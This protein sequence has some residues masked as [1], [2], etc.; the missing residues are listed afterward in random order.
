M[1]IL[2]ILIWVVLAIVVNALASVL[3]KKLKNNQKSAKEKIMIVLVNIGRVLL[4]I[5]FV[6]M[7]LVAYITRNVGLKNYDDFEKFRAESNV[8]FYLP[9]GAEDVK[10]AIDNKLFARTY[11]YSY[12]LSDDELEDFIDKMIEEKY[13]IKNEDGTTEVEFNKY[14]GIKVSEIDDVDPYELDNFQHSL[15]FSS[16][17]DDSIDDYIVIYYYPLNIGT[18]G[19]GIMYN[20]NTNRVVEYYYGQVR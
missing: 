10:T 7:G 13:T 1:K 3:T 6:I 2:K 17:I 11:I 12:V 9:S 8:D 4:T 14:Y 20:K 19:K 16:V 18:T 15:A 5:V